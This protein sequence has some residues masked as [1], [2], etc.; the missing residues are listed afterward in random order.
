MQKFRKNKPCLEATGRTLLEPR[1]NRRVRWPAAL[2]HDF[3]QVG[4]WDAG[5]A[6]PEH[7]PKG[8]GLVALRTRDVPPFTSV[9]EV[10]RRGTATTSPMALTHSIGLDKLHRTAHFARHANDYWHKSTV[11]LATG[12]IDACLNRMSASRR[13]FAF[14]SL[15]RPCTF[16]FEMARDR[17]RRDLSMHNETYSGSILVL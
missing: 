1:G 17:L 14:F 8:R 7:S 13:C 4:K 9:S 15:L 16:S 6:T 10:M 5:M 2:P 3:G 11:F 12:E